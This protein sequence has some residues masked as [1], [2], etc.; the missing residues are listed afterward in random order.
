MKARD[1]FSALEM[2]PL[3][4]PRGMLFS[5]VVA[6][7]AAD[8]HLGEHSAGRGRIGCARSGGQSIRPLNIVAQNRDVLM[9]AQFPCVVGKKDARTR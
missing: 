9:G 5:S 7:A 8:C 2:W 1:S 4:L 6:G 3:S